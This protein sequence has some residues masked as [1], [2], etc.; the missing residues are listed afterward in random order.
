MQAADFFSDDVGLTHA[1]GMLA[2]HVFSGARATQDVG[3]PADDAEGEPSV[4]TVCCSST[5][6]F[7]V[8]SD[9]CSCVLHIMK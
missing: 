1:C 5:T 4:E 9:K 8:E 2:A 7:A 6:V 3:S